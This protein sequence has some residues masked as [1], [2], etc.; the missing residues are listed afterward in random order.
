M[1]KGLLYLLCM[2]GGRGGTGEG[3]SRAWSLPVIKS[4]G[5]FYAEWHKWLGM[6]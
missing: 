2:V 1:R 4:P 6:G 3:L 5:Q